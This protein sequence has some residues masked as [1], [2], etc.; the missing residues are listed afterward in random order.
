MGPEIEAQQGLDGLAR[1]LYAVATGAAPAERFPIR[2]ISDPA[3][4]RAIL[5]RPDAF[6]K[7]Y[8]FLTALGHGRFT[9]NGDDWTARARVTQPSYVESVRRLNEETVEALYRDAIA[10]RGDRSREGLFQAL[11]DVALAVV[12]RAFG[13]TTPLNWSHDWIERTRALLA[14]RQWIGFVGAAP[15]RLRAQ[16][17]ALRSLRDEIVALWAQ[18]PQAAALLVRLDRLGQ[19]V[20]DFDAGDEL[21]QNVIASSETTAASLLWAAEMLVVHPE[22]RARVLSGDVGLNRFIAE[23]LRLFPP[24]PFVTRVSLGAIKIDA[25]AFDAGE[26]L[27]IS[28][29]GLHFDSHHWRDPLIF[30]PQRSE[31]D[32]KG[33][34]PSAFL[35][36]STGPR[37]C[38]GARLARIELRAGVRALAQT[39]AVDAPSQAPPR[40]R[41][42]LSMRAC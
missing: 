39:A 40:M 8:D 13:L 3:T 31:F 12:S 11:N 24:V 30:D 20:A 1:L 38:G 37:V 26:P 4:A 21:I 36:F 17:Q 6:V 14:V 35:P 42:G 15:Q 10:G 29:V 32:D 16:E 18:D 19:D 25:V 22:Q 2:L 27:A 23:V 34:G 9:A 5:Q 33:R 28:I 7:N 41:Y